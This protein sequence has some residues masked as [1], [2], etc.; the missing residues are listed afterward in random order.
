MVWVL[1]LGRSAMRCRIR[2]KRND[3]IRS[4]TFRRF[5]LTPCLHRERCITA[6]SGLDILC[7]NAPVGTRALNPLQINAALPRQPPNRWRS[8]LAK[9]IP[10]LRW[11]GCE[12]VQFRRLPARRNRACGTV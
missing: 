5:R 9:R 8:N 2:L 7:G 12:V 4:Q 10:P 3:H 6:A 1:K 11:C